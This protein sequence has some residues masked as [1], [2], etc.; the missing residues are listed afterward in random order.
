[1]FA[2]ITRTH[3]LNILIKKLWPEI[4][5]HIKIII[6]ALIC[7]ALVSLFKGIAP[8]ILKRLTEAWQDNDSQKAL[9]YPI[10]LA[11]AWILS[12]IFRYFN[13]YWMVYTSEKIAVS[14]RKKL[15]AKYLQLNL[16]YRQ[17]LAEG[18]GGLISRMLHDVVVI[19]HGIA[20]LSAFFREPILILLSLGYLIRSDWR[21]TLLI[22]I[23]L[24]LFTYVLKR[25]SKSL[26]K[27]SHLNQQAMEALT[28]VLKESLDGTRIV[29]SFNLQGF[30]KERFRDKAD[31]YLES[32][33]KIV[34]RELVSGPITE[35][36][37]SLI[38]C[39]L[40][41]YIGHSIQSQKMEISNFVG[42]IVAIGLLQD[43]FKKLQNSI[44]KVQQ[45][46][47]ALERFDDLLESKEVVPEANNP[48]PFPM[49]WNYIHFKDVCFNYDEKPALTNL[50][51]T[52]K[53]GQ[54]VALVGPSGSGKST[55]LNLLERFY[56][57]HSGAIYIDDINIKDISLHDLRRNIGLVSQE[58]FLFSDTVQKNIES[59]NFEN[60]TISFQEAANIANAENFIKNKPDSYNTK[61]SD[62]GYG[63]SGGEKQ[64]VS[65]A[66][67]VY[68]NAPIL[69]LDEATSALDSDSEKE[70]QKGL[71]KLMKGKT[72]LIIA[73]R[74]STVKNADKIYVL[75]QGQLV[76]SGQH[77][78]LVALNGEYKRLYDI[79]S[80]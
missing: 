5:P 17:S 57:P 15:M 80:L 31:Y 39:G 13:N 61:V 63:L 65:I 27:H 12:S 18:A 36:L 2:L 74:L 48:V 20:H 53:K 49:D 56:D 30:M 59:G 8:D 28:K 45:S 26:K 40:L 21:L 16:A 52:I 71:E 78:E 43:S 11:G 60:K 77:N 55:L 75:K 72:A 29:Q 47:V 68:K 42:F 44:V 9:L 67:A 19:Q 38:L 73:H 25:I 69:L 22:V 58:I 37:A 76:E 34:S 7:G 23:T 62:G 66:R 10:A 14:I 3:Q 32:R 51:L 6:A 33:R 54:A 50:N 41:M 24:P 46:I 70:V 4:K 35:S 64:R 1:M 79:Q